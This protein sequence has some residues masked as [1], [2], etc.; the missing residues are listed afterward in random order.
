[1]ETT[2]TPNTLLSEESQATIRKMLLSLDALC[3]N[4]SLWKY[5][6]I[7][8]AMEQMF[9]G[10]FSVPIFRY[11]RLR[12]AYIIIRRQILHL[13]SLEKEIAEWKKESEKLLQEKAE[14]KEKSRH[15][16]VPIPLFSKS[17]SPYG[18]LPR[19]K[20]IPALHLRAAIGGVRRSREAVSKMPQ[21]ITPPKDKQLKINSPPISIIN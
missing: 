14:H 2:P 15:I 19:S 16:N 3:G 21:G 5:D 11:P 13:L 1:M 12:L 18:K 7:E 20:V 4:N 8:R 10:D 17:T 6:D 9:Q